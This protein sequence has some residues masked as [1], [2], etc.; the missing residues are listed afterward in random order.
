ME[1]DFVLFGVHIG[2]HSFKPDEII[3]EIKD[4]CIDCGH[5]FVV[6]RCPVGVQVPQ[7]YYIKWAK[8]LSDHQIYFAFC[9]TIQFAPAGKESH[10][11]YETVAQ[12]KQIAGKYY[13]GDL[14]GEVGSNYACKW[15]HYYDDNKEGFMPVTDLPDMQVAYDNYQKVMQKWIDLENKYDMPSIVC[16]EATSLHKYNIASGIDIPVLELMCGHPEIL[17][18]LTRGVARAS[19]SPMWGTYLA[20]EW[21]GGYRHEDMLKRQRMKVAM[22]YAYLSGSQMFCLES[23]DESIVSFGYKYD[24]DHEICKEYRDEW[25]SFSKFIREDNRPVGGP[26]VKVAIVQGNHDAWGSWGG[27]SV[28]NQFDRPEWGHGEAEHSWRLLEDLHSKRS[29]G[30]IANHGD[31][32]LS[33]NPAY[34]MYDVI[35]AEAPAEVYKK[36]DYVI[37][38]GWNTMTDEIFDNLVA[39]VEN[40]GMLLMTAAHLNYSPKRNGERIYPSNE[41]LEKLFG[42]RFTGKTVSTNSGLKFRVDTPSGLLYPGTKNMRCDP[43]FSAGYVS[44][45]DTVV[46]TGFVA[47]EMA[48]DFDEE[49]NA[50]PMIIENKLGN[51]TAILVTAEN[52][53]GQ[54]ALMPMYRAIM[55][56]MISDSARKCDV[57]VISSDTLRYSVYEDGK[58]YLLNTDFDMP[59]FVKIIYNGKEETI[60]LEPI[61]LKT[62]QL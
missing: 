37:F 56:E 4:R 1:R 3:A 49:P 5:N 30:E 18:S 57:K 13:L 36:Y 15:K 16:V 12:M 31:H 28:W 38:L 62:Y 25:A 14:L 47:G 42:C 46:T 52:Y 26:K 32:D 39:Y 45:A 48:E 11:T 43:I 41:K 51:G 55:R 19:D 50:M 61:E 23:G 33:A 8:Y 40:G 2:E 9:Y 58:M 20:H 34:G 35:P 22:R 27:S 10:F 17:T 53:P 24:K 21:Y 59:I 29:W 54:P 6:I 60:T 7:E 44:F